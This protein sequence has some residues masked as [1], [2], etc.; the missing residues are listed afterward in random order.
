MRS[1]QVFQSEETTS[2]IYPPGPFPLNLCPQMI[3]CSFL[4]S[5]KRFWWGPIKKV[6][7]RSFFRKKHAFH[8]LIDKVGCGWPGLSQPSVGGGDSTSCQCAGGLQAASKGPVRGLSS[9]E[10]QA[11]LHLKAWEAW[12][13]LEQNPKPR[14]FSGVASCCRICRPFG[15]ALTP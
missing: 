7:L 11:P 13:S 8:P 5:E 15:L 9:L 1:F 12:T 4:F 2:I 14:I 10:R 3:T 6:P